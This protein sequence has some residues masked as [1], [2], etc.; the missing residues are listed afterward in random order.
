MMGEYTYYLVVVFFTLSYLIIIHW[1]FIYYRFNRPF[2]TFL[3][4]SACTAMM[5]TSIYL[6]GWKFEPLSVNPMIGP[7]AETLLKLGAKDSYLIVVQ[8]EIWRIASPMVLHAGEYM[9]CACIYAICLLFH[10]P[11]LSFQFHRS[12]S[13]LS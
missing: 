9:L 12:D 13:L 5:V 8:Q 10:I 1:H 11:N 3:V 4:V 6:N 7:S 2:F